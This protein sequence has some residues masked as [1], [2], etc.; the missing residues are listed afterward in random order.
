MHSN[1]G[2]LHRRPHCRCG[3]CCCLGIGTCRGRSS[4]RR[5]SR[6]W[7]LC[8][9]WC[10]YVI[11]WAGKGVGEGAG[12]GQEVRARMYGCVCVVVGVGRCLHAGPNV[13]CVCRPARPR[14]L[15]C[16]PPATVALGLHGSWPFLQACFCNSLEAKAAGRTR[17]GSK[18]TV[19]AAAVRAC[20]TPPPLSR[21]PGALAGAF[22]PVCRLRWEAKPLTCAAEFVG[23]MQPLGDGCSCPTHLPSW[24]TW[25]VGFAICLCRSSAGAMGRGCC[26]SSVFPEALLVCGLSR[27][28]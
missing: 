1:S 18:P 28:P 14:L 13:V 17:R 11:K 16:F 20:T 22:L 4:Q 24:T 27:A 6:G 7:R 8:R 2:P 23:C 26:G 10:L 9:L 12:A 25:W 5:S 15:Y 19:L 3:C 21:C